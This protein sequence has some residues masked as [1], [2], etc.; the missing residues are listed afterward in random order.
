[1]EV[2]HPKF[3][4]GFLEEVVIIL[5]SISLAVIA[6]RMVEHYVHNKEG[7]EALARLAAEMKR[8]TEDFI[9]N[10]NIHKNALDAEDKITAWATGAIEIALMTNAFFKKD[11]MW[12][13][14]QINTATLR[15]QNDT[16]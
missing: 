11:F 3:V 5:V 8:D 7:K 6:E 15:Y 4:K 1:M 2:H 16:S 12:I 13:D 10:V 9:F 14:P